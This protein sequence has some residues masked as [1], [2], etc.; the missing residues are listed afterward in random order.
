[1]IAG[2]LI[3]AQHLCT[4][5]YSFCDV[6][7][8]FCCHNWSQ[9]EFWYFCTI[10]SAILSIIGYFADAGPDFAIESPIENA[11]GRRR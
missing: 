5:S 8:P 11:D 1:L 2:V 10:L 4:A 6:D 9:V 7:G 3:A